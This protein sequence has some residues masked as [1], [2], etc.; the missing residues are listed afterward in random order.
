MNNQEQINQNPSKQ[1]VKPPVGELEIKNAEIDSTQKRIEELT[2]LN[3]NEKNFGKEINRANEI[4]ALKIKLEEL[5]GEKNRLLEAKYDPF[6]A[7]VER[8]NGGAIRK[9]ERRAGF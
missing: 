7:S 4:K 8:E 9:M 5:L 1:E 6:S 3:K 2:E